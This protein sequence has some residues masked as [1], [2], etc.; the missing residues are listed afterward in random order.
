M[1]ECKGCKGTGNVQSAVA[2]EVALMV[3]VSVQNAG[4]PEIAQ[5]AMARERPSSEAHFRATPDGDGWAIACK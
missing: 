2:V 5:Y 1:A 3:L 4:A